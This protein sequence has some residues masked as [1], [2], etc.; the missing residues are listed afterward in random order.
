MKNLIQKIFV[1]VFF[2][3][4][5]NMHAT[6]GVSDAQNLSVAIQSDGNIVTVGYVT[7]N[8][9]MQFSAVRY[10]SFGIPDT[11]YGN[12][13]YV[14]TAFGSGA[15]ASGVALLSN[16]EAIVAGFGEPAAGTSF[17]IGLFTTSGTLDTSFNSTGTNTTLIGAGSAAHSITIDSSGNYVTAGVAV[18]SGTP[19]T[20]LARYTPSGSLDSTFG[21]GGV[22]TTQ[23]GNS[24]DG[25]SVQLQSNGQIVVGGYADVSGTN[26][27]VARYNTNGTLDTTFNSS[28]TLPG[29]VTTAIGSQAIAYALGIQS[30]G[31][32]VAAG[33]SNNAFALA[34]Y[35]TSGTLDT[36]FGSSGIVTTSIIGTSNAQINGM[37]IQSNGQIVVVGFA[38]DLLAVA[39]YNSNGTLDTTGFN[40]SGSQPGVVTTSIGEYAVGTCVIVNSSG[41]IIVGGYSD[42]G[43]LVARY[44]SSGTLDTTFG[45]NGYTS[46]PNSSVGPDIFG[47]TSANIASN[48]EIEYSQLD[49]T[50][51]IMDSDIN[52]NAGIEDTKLGTIQTSGKVLNS[53]TTATSTNTAS[54]IVTRDTL[55]NF[56]TNTITAS[57]IGNVS[58]A[59]SSNLL[60]SG[61]TMTG[62]LVLPAGSPTNPSLQF[63]GSTN[64]GLSATGNI[65]TLSTNG[66]GALSIDGNGAVT[67]ATPGSSEVG[68]TIDGGGATITGNVNTSTGI[69]FNSAGTSLN[70]VGSTQGP[71]LKIYTGTANTGLLGSVTINYSAA[72]FTQPPSIF[73]NSVSGII[74]ALGV[75]SVTSTSAIIT[76]VSLS[77]PLSFIAVGV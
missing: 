51:S 37:V 18:V 72:G 48:A 49:L 1:A 23:I 44:T 11:T 70:A 38:D 30:S 53:A 5:F 59:A 40:S 31:A 58:G 14:A 24:S 68:L 36:T 15:E 62:S 17:A 22:V 71:L 55:G 4:V 20:A 34:Q 69:V 73:T 66:A 29:T 25:Y 32:I 47:L 76:S 19:I 75:N 67:I 61:G 43:A 57:L 21:T 77:V 42:Q 10:N 63:S 65:L 46:F 6:P 28:G 3:H 9:V 13:G 27:A 64:S 33:A 16:N 52:T 50:D 41:Q 74:A 12:S 2:F 35:T 56:S 45:T 60:T 26:F 39:R 54:A 7:L 8:N